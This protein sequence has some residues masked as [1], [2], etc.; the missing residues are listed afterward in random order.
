LI[1]IVKSTEVSQGDLLSAIPVAPYCD[2]F[3]Q[4][5]LVQESIEDSDR[6]LEP[7][8]IGD[9]VSHTLQYIVGAHCGGFV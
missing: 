8:L 9:E 3:A 1:A 4:A 6:F 7:A 2:G 5:M